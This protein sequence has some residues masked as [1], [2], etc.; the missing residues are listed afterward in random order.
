M[1]WMRPSGSSIVST[2]FSTTPVF[3]TRTPLRTARRKSGNL[4]MDVNL[5][6]T[7]LMS[8]A[9]LPHMIEQHHGVIIN[10]SSGWGIAGGDAAVAYCAS[11][12]NG[13]VRAG[14]HRGAHPPECADWDQPMLAAGQ[15]FLA[16]NR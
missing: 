16:P 10:N 4:Q 7:F 8:K 5:K 13:A 14:S 12:G 15:P 6:G 9:V 1:L 11:K 2:F 3:S